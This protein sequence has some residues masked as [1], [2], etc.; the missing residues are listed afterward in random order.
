[1]ESP[2]SYPE[3]G[4]AL[5]ASKHSLR[6]DAG[7]SVASRRD[8]AARPLPMMTFAGTHPRI[9]DGQLL[10]AGEIVGVVLE[11]DDPEAEARC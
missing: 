9:S 4:C 5:L 2:G 1:L 3:N 11:T 8:Q 7:V 6:H 10:T